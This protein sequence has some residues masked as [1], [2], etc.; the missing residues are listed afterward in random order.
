MHPRVHLPQIYEQ[1]HLWS[2]AVESYVEVGARDQA[3]ALLQ[4]PRARVCARRLNSNE[5]SMMGPHPIEYAEY[6]FESLLEFIFS[7]SAK[8]SRTLFC[9]S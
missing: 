9:S 6:L 2:D 8:N 3:D 7:L 1:L 4:V 5:R